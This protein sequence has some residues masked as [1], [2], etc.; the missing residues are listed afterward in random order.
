MTNLYRKV[1]LSDIKNIQT[2]NMTVKIILY[3]VDLET[4]T[5]ITRPDMGQ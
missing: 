1:Y 5:R 4:G 2:F 3:L